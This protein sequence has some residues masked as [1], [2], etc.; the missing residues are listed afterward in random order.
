LKKPA[1][2]FFLFLF[3][4][5]L[6]AQKHE[7]GIS[8]GASN[9]K[10]DFTND[11]FEAKNYRPAALLFYQN[12]ITP[13]FGIRYHL[14]G[15]VITANDGKSADGVYQ[16]RGLSVSNTIYELGLQAMYNFLN[17]RSQT[18]R[19]K[20]TPYFTGG[21]GV[22]YYSPYSGGAGSSVGPCIPIGAG[23]KFIV[24]ENWNV[25]IE[26]VARKTFTDLID[27]TNGNTY[28][29]N[30]DTRDWYIYNGLTLSYTFYDVYCPKPKH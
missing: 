23:I 20:W 6:W 14:L 5:L 21:I 18:N 12:N 19:I 16:K 27:N 22:F 24:K 26:A 2:F 11:N 17:Y 10:G 4:S 15:G 28:G 8:L 29:G 9:Y 7:F 3:C 25:G 30:S 1:L 13:A